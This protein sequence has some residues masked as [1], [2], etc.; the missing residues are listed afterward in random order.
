[1]TTP[2]VYLVPYVDGAWT[3]YDPLSPE[4]NFSAPRAPLATIENNFRTVCELMGELVE[5]RFV[6][7]AHTGTYCRDLFYR[8]PM[9]S[10]YRQMLA[11]GGELALHPHEEVVGEGTL[12][13]SAAHMRKVITDKAAELR[14]AGLTATAYRGGY[15]AYS[16]FVT[17]VLEEEGIFVELSAAP[18]RENQLWS[19]CWREAAPSAYYLCSDDPFHRDCNDER[20]PVLEIPMGWDGR[21]TELDRNYLWNEMA[22]LESM[23]QTWSAVLERADASGEPQIIHFLSHLFAMEDTELRERCSDFLRFAL[24]NGAEAVTPSGAKAVY[25]RRTAEVARPA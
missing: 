2:T 14:E 8:E 1:M 19:S 15:G 24:A 13:T 21:G 7:A 16:K 4:A 11:H 18:G 20:S 25:D 9:L 5:G 22:S 10:G 12:V 23:K 17:P 3:G 6:F